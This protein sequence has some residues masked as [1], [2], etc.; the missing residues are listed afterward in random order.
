MTFSRNTVDACADTIASDLDD[1]FEKRFVL[2]SQN[3]GPD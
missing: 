2:N 1:H 3:D